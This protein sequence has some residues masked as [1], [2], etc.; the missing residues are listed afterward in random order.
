MLILQL[1]F[2]FLYLNVNLPLSSTNQSI[3]NSFLEQE[4]GAKILLLL[5]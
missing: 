1:N 5:K 2:H 3:T 4:T